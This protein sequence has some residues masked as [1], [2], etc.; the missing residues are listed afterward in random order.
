[1]RKFK[2]IVSLLLV[3]L[4]IVVVSSAALK[5]LSLDELVE[6][7][8]EIEQEL[9]SRGY[10][11][12]EPL[13][14][15]DEGEAVVRLQDKLTEL[16]YFDKAVNG[17]YGKTTESAVKAFQK[18]NEMEQDGIATIA[19]QERL[20]SN[21]VIAK[22]T[23]TPKPTKVPPPTPTPEPTPVPDNMVIEITKVK[24]NESRNTKNF[25]VDLKNHSNDLTIDAFT[26]TM[27]VYDVYG[28]QLNKDGESAEWWKE[29]SIKPGKSFSMGSYYWYLFSEQTA[30][31]ITVAITKYHI[32]DGATVEIPESEY[33]WVEGELRK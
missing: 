30:A 23:P 14:K 19:V 3:L 7:K 24:L 15:G 20:Y 2:S 10:Y 16:Y 22:A 4:S 13:Q 25:S 12:L 21:T 26:V 18:D 1:M 29:L 5:D 33:V 28:E 32:K 27:K 31:K 6:Q 11:P 8:N 17:E 9:I